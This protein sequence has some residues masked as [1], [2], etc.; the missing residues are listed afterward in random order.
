MSASVDIVYRKDKENKKGKS[1]I[2][3]RITKNRRV[4]YIATDHKLTIDL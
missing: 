4:Q 3:V 1:P 2:Y